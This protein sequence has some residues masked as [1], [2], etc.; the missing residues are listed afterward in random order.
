MFDGLPAQRLVAELARL[1]ELLAAGDG[2]GASPLPDA[3]VVDGLAAATA[4]AGWAEGL[5]VR[6]IGRLRERRRADHDQLVAELG[7]RR[8]V[9]RAGG[10]ASEAEV[11]RFTAVEVAAAL[12]VSQRSA[13][14]RVQLADVLLRR[15]PTTLAALS[16]GLVGLGHARAV[17]DALEGT[18]DDLARRVETHVIARR[19]ERRERQAPEEGG[20]TT[21]TIGTPSQVSAAVRRALATA[22]PASATRRIEAARCR[23]GVTSWGLPDG[24]AVLQVTAPA[25]DVAAAVAGVDA[26]AREQVDA[27]RRA[28]RAGDLDAV[29]VP[30][31][32]QARA[33]AAMTLLLGTSDVLA[34]PVPHV[35]VGVDVLVPLAALLPPPHATSSDAVPDHAP[36][37]LPGFGPLPDPVARAVARAARRVTVAP[38]RPDGTVDAGCPGTHEARYEP[39]ATLARAVRTRDVTCRWPGCRR[40]AREADLDHTVEWPTG[41]TAGCNLAGYCRLHHRAKHRGGWLVTQTGDGH[42]DHTAPTGHTYGTD[43]PSWQPPEDVDVGRDDDAGPGPAPGDWWDPAWFDADWYDPGE[44]PEADG[45]DRI[46]VLVA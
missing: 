20:G 34:R 8:A 24:L 1:E 44:P 41:P 22:D 25:V 31:L 45:D 6:L 27:A 42:L 33:D 3:A 13:Q 35:S 5:S 26:V 28:H 36:A 32:D 12:R 16:A 14:E 19:L 2:P 21:W 23:R 10:P 4:L 9:E 17:R 29:D 37:E 43:P 40:R 7:G 38:L 18:R 15:Q 39:S 30:T 11:D 46:G